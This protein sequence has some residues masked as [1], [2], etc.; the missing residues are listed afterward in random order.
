MIDLTTLSYTELL[1]LQ[2]QL[3]SAITERAVSESKKAKNEWLASDEAKP[4]LAR[5][6]AMKKK[7]EALSKKCGKNKSVDLKVRLNVEFDPQC[8]DDVLEGRWER[9][10]CELFEIQ[11][12][13]E[14]LNR[15]ACGE[16]GQ[17]VENRVADVMDDVCEEAAKLH[18][19]L[20]DECE[21]FVEEYNELISELRSSTSLE[22]S[23]AD[24][25]K[26]DVAAQKKAAKKK[27]KKG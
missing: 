19:K 11:C 8:F 13:G 24:I 16:L 25:V 2:K 22:V 23:P 21:E 27:A 14:L 17:E 6:Q 4:Y 7:Y 1:D 3:E 9:S 12:G 20:Y 18:G 26:S 5:I 15:K 10:F